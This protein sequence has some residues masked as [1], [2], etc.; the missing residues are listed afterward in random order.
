MIAMFTLMVVFQLKHWAADYVLQAPAFFIGK[1]KTD[2]G[3]VWPLTVHVLIHAAFTFSI[4]LWFGAG[5][6][7][8]AG[9]ALMDAGI[10]FVMDRAKASPRY[11]GRWKALSGGEWMQAQKE[12]ACAEE[13]HQ[14][15]ARK[16]LRGNVLFWQCLGLDQLV[17]H[18]T[19]IAVIW[20]LVGQ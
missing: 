14:A 13:G 5:R 16:S 15:S 20:F 7:K 1:F 10:H 8:A 3:F 4:C 2:W 17:H 9:L 19:D 6:E 11:L 12:L 18:L